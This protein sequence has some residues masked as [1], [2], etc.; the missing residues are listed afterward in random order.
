MVCPTPGL[1]QVLRH[2][3]PWWPLHVL[4]PLC[5]TLPP[6]ST[7][8]PPTRPAAAA[9]P[10]HQSYKHIQ[11]CCGCIPHPQLGLCVSVSPQRSGDHMCPRHCPV[12]SS[13]HRASSSHLRGSYE[14][15]PGQPGNCGAGMLQAARPQAS[16]D[17]PAK[18]PWA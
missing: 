6:L 16:L 10:E 5:G 13:Q 4:C 3:P 7:S 1:L 2:S 8:P 15:R 18:S 11:V 17:P 12:P 14:T 9:A